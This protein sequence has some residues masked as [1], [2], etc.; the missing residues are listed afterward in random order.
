MGTH[1]NTSNW[2]GLGNSSEGVLGVGRS[3]NSK[4]VRGHATNGGGAVAIYGH[5]T[6][7][8]AGYFSGKVHVTSTLTKAGGAFKIDHPLEPDSKYLYHSF[9]ESP[10]MMNIYN[11]NAIL[12]SKGEAWVELPDWFQA[13]NKDNR[14]QLTPIGMPGPNLH[15]AEKIS[16][17]RF[18]IA[19]GISG[20]EVSWQVTGVRQDAY[21][22]AHRIQVEVEKQG[23]ER[24]KLLHPVEHGMPAMMGVNYD[25]QSKMEAEITR[26]SERALAIEAADKRVEQDIKAE[27][28]Q[29]MK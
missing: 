8:W 11:G 23:K 12:D 17:N 25:D 7:G 2:G 22:N 16:N 10:D 29:K 21:A 4:G 27:K 26:M 14:Y 13:L 15:I 9:V 3:S 18:K 5:S 1:K 24:G 28:S 6:N 20:M 19:G